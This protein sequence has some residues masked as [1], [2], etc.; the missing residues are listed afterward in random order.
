ML[1]IWFPSILL[2]D[3]MLFICRELNKLQDQKVK[4]VEAVLLGVI[5]SRVQQTNLRVTEQLDT[6][7][8]QLNNIQQASVSTHLATY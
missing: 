2:S 6:V 1:F 8:R 3:Y 5:D 7:L 4:S